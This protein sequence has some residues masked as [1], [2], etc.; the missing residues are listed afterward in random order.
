MHTYTENNLLNDYLW[1]TS[2]LFHIPS[3][4]LRV[5]DASFYLFIKK[6]PIFL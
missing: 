6:T 2:A 4:T 5:G 1:P 3:W